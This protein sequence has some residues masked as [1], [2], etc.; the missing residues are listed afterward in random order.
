M[1]QILRTIHFASNDNNS[2]LVFTITCNNLLFVE[3][4]LCVSAFLWK[5]M[6]VLVVHCVMQ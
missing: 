2:S 1:L 3:Q 6:V 5:L 4:R